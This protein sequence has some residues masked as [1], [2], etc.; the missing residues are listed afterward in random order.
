M[1]WHNDLSHP[2]LTQTLLKSIDVVIPPKSKVETFDLH[3]EE[4]TNKNKF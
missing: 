4:W 2:L 1:V 3:V